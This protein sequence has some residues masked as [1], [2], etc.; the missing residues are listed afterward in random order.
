MKGKKQETKK[1]KQREKKSQGEGQPM[2]LGDLL[3]KY[4]LEDK[5]GYIT[6]EFQDY[7]YRLAVEL[8]DEEHK[9]LYIRLA[10]TIDRGLLEEA[11]SFVQDAGARKPAA[12]FMWK[13]KQ[14][15]DE[16]RQK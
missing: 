1:K 13:L 8:G 9:A 12:L 15:R 14:L 6:R 7:G 2:L 5:G 11:R 16:A 4:E 3:K 10:K